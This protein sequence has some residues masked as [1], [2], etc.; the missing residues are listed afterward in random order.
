MDDTREGIVIEE[1]Y[2]EEAA[3]L[4]A[5]RRGIAY[6]RRC[7]TWQDLIGRY[8]DYAKWAAT[9]I[10]HLPGEI[11]DLI[12]ET[13]GVRAWWRDGKR[14]GDDGPAVVKADGTAIE[15]PDGTKI[16]YRDG[17]RHRD[18]GPAVVLPNGTMKWHRYGELHR[19]DGPAV[20]KADGTKEW[21]RDGKRHRD[22]G[23]AV[24]LPD[25]TK[26]WWRNG[27]PHRD[28]GPAIERPDGTMEWWCNGV[29]IR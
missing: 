24:E 3:K 28:D 29:K 20:V 26:I 12:Y 8:P 6:S 27:E 5:C 14:H 13:M 10:P 1:R 11:V 9:N 15:L 2:F 18:D 19:D 21:W 16:W 4:G 23:P 17:K 25:G 22:D 7:R